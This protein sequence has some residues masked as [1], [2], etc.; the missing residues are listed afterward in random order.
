MNLVRQY[1]VTEKTADQLVERYPKAQIHSHEGTLWDGNFKT[2][3]DSE[4]KKR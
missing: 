1:H 3:H 2:K 4:N